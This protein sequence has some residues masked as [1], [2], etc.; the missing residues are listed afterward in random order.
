MLPAAELVNSGG[1]IPRAPSGPVPMGS[2]EEIPGSPLAMLKPAMLLEL[3]KNW[4]ITSPKPRVTSA[5]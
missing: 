4:V 2:I 3:R 5:R 1:A